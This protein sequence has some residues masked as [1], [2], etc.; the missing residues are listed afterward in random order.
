MADL[1]EYKISTRSGKNT[2]LG[3]IV[4]GLVGGA[5]TQGLTTRGERKRSAI[6]MTEA[7]HQ[8][9]LAKDVKT[10][11]VNED[12]RMASALAEHGPLSSVKTH[13][14]SATYAARNDNQ[15]TGELTKSDTEKHTNSDPNTISKP[16]EPGAQH[17]GTATGRVIGGART[18]EKGPGSG[19][20]LHMFTEKGNPSKHVK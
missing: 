13:S 5:V 16:I 12:I 20:Q 19:A 9:G 17:G 18:H 2:M 8:V 10:H 7:E 1:P 11:M 4:G 6:R 15:N 14:G 3:N